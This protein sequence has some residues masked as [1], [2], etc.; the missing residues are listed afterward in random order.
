MAGPA[1]YETKTRA[2]WT[3]QFY[4]Q[5]LLRKLRVDGEYRRGYFYVPYLPGSDSSLDSRAWYVAGAYRVCKQIEV[6][7]YYSHYQVRTVTGGLA[8]LLTPSQS[9]P[10]LPQNHVYDKVVAGRVDLNR[11]VYL[12]LEGHLMNGFGI[13]AYPDGFYPQQNASGFRPN[14]NALVVKTGFHF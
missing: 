6:G 8:A 2:D 3:N 4:G 5:F 13:A 11:F 7:S 12:K 1:P 14:T 9:N 10:E